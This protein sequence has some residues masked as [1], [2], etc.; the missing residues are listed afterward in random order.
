[1]GL[2]G[3]EMDKE[4]EELTKEQTELVDKI[5]KM[6]EFIE[7]DEFEKLDNIQKALIRAQYKAMDTYNQILFERIIHL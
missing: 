4:M 5:N 1:M 6:D 3:H 7:S 2:E